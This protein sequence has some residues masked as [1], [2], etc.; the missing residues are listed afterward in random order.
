[1]HKDLQ[2][3]SALFGGILLAALSIYWF[4]EPLALFDTFCVAQPCS[5]AIV[6]AGLVLV[7]GLS[8]MMAGVVLLVRSKQVQTVSIAIN[9][10]AEADAEA[11]GE[12][13]QAIER[14]ENPEKR[15]AGKVAS[16]KRTPAI[17]VTEFIQ[18]PK[19]ELRMKRKKK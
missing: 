18:L 19:E 15:L 1:M 17:D 4:L 16:S 9:D 8:L 3:I 7:L 14:K 12:L 2:W 11:I 13:E 10:E 6:A 5:I